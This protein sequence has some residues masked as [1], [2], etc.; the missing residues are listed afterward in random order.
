MHQIIDVAWDVGEHAERLAGAGVRTVLRYYNHRNSDRLPSKS[1]TQRE[2]D[3]LFRAGL[4]VGVVFQQRG[5]AGGHIAD[6]SDAAGRRDAQRA[7]SLASSLGQPAGSGIYFGVDHDYFRSSELAAVQ[8]YFR[9]VRG[10]IGTLYRVGVYGSGTVGRALKA[11]G[12]VDLIWLAAA[13]GWSGTRLALQQGDW[14][15]DQRFLELRSEIGGFI[16]DGN[17][18]NPACSD[19]GQFGPGGAIVSPAGEGTA[20]LY[21]VIARSGLNL[22][23]TPGTEGRVIQS[24]PASSVV[25]GLERTGEWIKVDLNGDGLADGYLFGTFLEPVS[26]D[27]PLN[28][29]ARRTPIEVARAELARDVRETPGSAHNP[30]ITMYHATTS[31]GVAPDETA[32]C[33]SFVNYCVEQAGLSGTRSKWARSWHETGWGRDVTANP[34]EGDLV[35]WRRRG[36]GEDGGHVGFYL[37]SDEGSLRVLGGNQGDRV[38]IKRYPRSGTSGAFRYDLLSIRRG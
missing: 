9:A 23:P 38:S 17:V 10:E 34:A 14:T 4:S 6:F 37:D 36:A 13:R 1:L 32:W 21:R 5:G 16:Y 2:L 22:R 25:R 3:R 19:F 24:L 31:G 12:L 27:L 28:L 35:V 7:L 26:G 8:S 30:R 15:L 18:F 29:P 20:A 33:S 11:A